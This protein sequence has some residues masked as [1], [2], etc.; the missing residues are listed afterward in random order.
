[1]GGSKQT[2]TTSAL[3]PELGMAQSAQGN[4][5]DLIAKSPPQVPI[6][7]TSDLNRLVN[8]QG[9]L[10]QLQS[11]VAEQ[12]LSPATAALRAEIPQDLQKKYEAAKAGNLDPG[13]Q[14]A[15][16]QSGLARGLST[17]LGTNPGTIGGVGA[18]QVLGRGAQDYINQI[19]SMVANYVNNQQQPDVSLSPEAAANISVG[20]QENLANAQNNWIQQ[21]IGGASQETG[22]LQNLG[23]SL[24]ESGANEDYQNALAKAQ[25]TQKVMSG[26]GTLAGGAL[27]TWAFPGV[28]TAVGANIGGS[29]GSAAGGMFG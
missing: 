18:A 21:L 11:R 16:I 20:N 22:N 24:A 19:Q 27:G 12:S 2:S 6:I 29:L 9:M 23:Q 1:M 25:H 3:A 4:L 7:S 15:L 10:G 13:V 8:Q 26:L 28:G 5:L 17:G 14:S